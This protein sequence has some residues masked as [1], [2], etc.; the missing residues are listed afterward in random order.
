MF[1]H[2]WASQYGT[3]AAGLAADTWGAVL[4][5]LTAEQ[6]ANGLHACAAEGREFPPS[7]PRFRG[8]CLGI[9]S[10]ARIQLEIRDGDPSPF[11]I[12]TWSKVDGYA[13]RNAQADKAERMLRAAYD[14]AVESVMRGEPLPVIAAKVEHEKRAVTPAPPEVAAKHIDEIRELLAVPVVVA[15]T[16]EPEREVPLSAI[17]AE[18]R[19]HYDHVHDLGADAE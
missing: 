2:T 16:P 4:T 14:L 1:G 6:L 3:V 11:A 7:A 15:P 12:A 8:M 10:F 13:Y 18:L 19:D 9:P 5:G 17:E